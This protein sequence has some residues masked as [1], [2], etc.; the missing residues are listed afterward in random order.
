MFVRVR[1]GEG[2]SLGI[3]KKLNTNGQRC[4]V[5][6]FDAPVSKPIVLDLDAGAIEAVTLPEQTRIY[7]FND[8]LGAW[9]IG[10]LLDDH[11]DKQFIRFP[12]GVSRYLKIS[13]VFVR[14]R[15]AIEDP[16]AFLGAKIS[17]TPR[18]VEGRKRFV[19]SA[20]AQR[21]AAMG[22]SALASSSVELEAHQIEV[23]RRILQDPVQRYLLADEVGLGKTIEAGIL[24]RQCILD[25][26]DRALVLV[27]VPEALVS[28]WRSELESKFFLGGSLD[29]TIHVL[30]FK[31]RNRIQPLLG[32]AAMLVIDEA[33]HLTGHRPAN[34]PGGLY[35]DIAAAAPTIERVLLLSATPALHNERGFLEMLHLLDHDTYKLTDQEGFRLRVENRQ[36]LAG[37]VAG[38]T[39]ENV[40]YLDHPLDCLAE[41]FP[42]DTLLQEQSRALRAISDKMPVEDDPALVEAV[43][44]VRAH[45][46]ESY[47]LH[48][49][50]LRHRRRSVAG[51]TPDRSGATV[52]NYAS[53]EVHRLFEAL[54][55]WRITEVSAVF[56]AE[57]D[58][59]RNNRVGVFNGV[60]NQILEY[61]NESGGAVE[62]LRRDAQ[63]TARPDLLGLVLSRLESGDYFKARCA[64]LVEKLQALLAPRQQ[65]VIFC[66]DVS[67]ADALALALA[68]RLKVVVDR[69]DPGNDNWL[70]FNL[71]PSR[72][73][74]VADHRAEEGLNLQGGR[75][76]VIHYDL[77][78]NP[79]R[80]EQRLGRADRYGSGDAVKSIVLNCC[81]NPI[82]GAWIDYLNTGLRVFDRSVASLQYLIEG[83]TR[84]LAE[85]LF[86]ECTEALVDLTV[87][88]A[89]KDGV[90]EREIR[91]IDEQDALDALGTPPSRMLE[92]LTDVDDD[93]Q[94][95]EG[96][97]S[98]WIEGT[99]QFA[100]IPEPT[101]GKGVELFR[102]RY[103]TSNRHTLVPLETFYES[104]RSSI[105]VSPA[106]HLARMVR[107]VPFTYRRRTALSRQGRAGGT[108]LLR[109]GDPFFTG[110]WEI[111]QADDRGRSTGLWRQMSD[112]RSD[113][114]ADLFFRFDFFVEAD[115]ERSC[116]V[117]AGVDRLTDASAASIVRRGDMLLPPFFRTVWLDQEL[118]PVLDFATLE[119][120]GLAYRPE[121]DKNGDRDFNLNSKRWQQMGTLDVPQLEHWADLC[122]KARVRAE[123][124][125][126]DLPSLTASLD[127][128]VGHAIEVDR[129]RLG[130][131]RARAERANSAADSLEWT[132][133]R[134]LSQ[135][136]MDGI[137]EP[138]I[139][140]DAIL[141]C[142]LSGNRAASAVLDAAREPNAHF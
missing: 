122:A 18:F 131:L 93:W 121:A 39:P 19:R 88:S 52:V 89:G 58:P 63:I 80:I 78:L 13:E 25:A 106:A 128:A 81:D 65:F 100:R 104:C 118:N 90:I 61:A 102:Y 110:M 115:V 49:R 117:L 22:M 12:N 127:I 133:E 125:L 56:G 50:I 34:H 77:P 48:R 98:S 55:D 87:Q 109:Y 132:L 3:G 4:S 85:S 31:E 37:I 27:I 137:R 123:A 79:N 10:R 75:K 28:Q 86:A 40:L 29:R 142:F 57:S 54:E 53:P 11:G 36:A 26:G 83:T 92:T 82:E 138:S 46:S 129:A 119:R 113:G 105:D 76:I 101:E 134:S 7:Y 44:R 112:Y 1:E 42:D 94:A 136:L 5:E 30:G 96:D 68:N 139:R 59:V 2:A 111:A 84:G 69:H 35:D 71:D 62:L 6:Y 107:T 141:A 64:A 17:E 95:I 16:T 51:L 99:L 67:T 43:G 24:I 130:Q 47:R 91:N 21:A 15:R 32:K 33:H 14:C 73:I 72:P 45:L 126:R 20:I 116:K 41:M 97:A 108:R 140:V 70:A 135:N 38:L 60:L 74:L 114:T 66:S 9:E 103:L 23:V 8:V 120:L 124:Y